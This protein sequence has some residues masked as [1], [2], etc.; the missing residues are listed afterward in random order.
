MTANR[1]ILGFA[2]VLIDIE[3]TDQLPRV[4]PVESDEGMIYQPV[5]Y[6]WRPEKCLKCGKYGHSA[7]VCGGPPVNVWVAKPNQSQSQEETQLQVV[8]LKQVSNE[9]NSFEI[10][11][12]QPQSKNAVEEAESSRIVKPPV[13]KKGEQLQ[14]ATQCDKIVQIPAGVQKQKSIEERQPAKQRPK[15]KGGGSAPTPTVP[16]G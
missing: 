4:I 6:E 3:I 16:N 5:H 14:I 10:H 15:D 2:R 1:D 7:M 11:L 12:E 9:Q 8:Q 13:S